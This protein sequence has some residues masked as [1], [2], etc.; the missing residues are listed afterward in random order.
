MAIHYY[1][2]HCNIPL[3]KIE[4]M[5]MHSDKLGLHTLTD[6]ER[7][8]MIDYDSSGD[9]YIKAICEDCHESLERNPEFYQNDYLIH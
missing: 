3:G 9:I 6:E 1:C 2:R 7:L 5:S 4:N 8:E